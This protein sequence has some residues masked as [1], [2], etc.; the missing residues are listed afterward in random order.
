M[1]SFLCLLCTFLP[2]C[3]HS[4]Q[5]S[6]VLMSNPDKVVSLIFIAACCIAFVLSIGGVISSWATNI[7]QGYDN[8]YLTMGAGSAITFD[9]RYDDY[10]GWYL[11]GMPRVISYG[12]E[13][14]V[15]G[16][17]VAILILTLLLI[18]KRFS[19]GIF[20]ET[21]LGYN[22]SYTPRGWS[23]GV[24]ELAYSIGY[25]ADTLEQTCTLPTVLSPAA[26]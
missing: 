15:G 9:G 23:C 24:Y 22:G 14:A 10:S 18:S 3:I 26:M 8:S 11:S 4:T 25:S 13:K 6:S 21:T 12:N 16:A 5:S 7:D 20:E 1:M 17:S 2:A 19:A